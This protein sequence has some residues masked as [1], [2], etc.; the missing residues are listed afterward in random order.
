MIGKQKELFPSA[1]KNY[2]ESSMSSVHVKCVHAMNPFLF[3]YCSISKIAQ[4]Y[5]GKPWAVLL[6]GCI[7]LLRIGE[8]SE[9]EAK[10]MCKQS[11]LQ[12][13]KVQ[14]ISYAN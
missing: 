3:S 8:L 7:N 11:K 1:L 4:N 6:T 5:A 13:R 12:R 9:N 10:Q 2:R 14:V